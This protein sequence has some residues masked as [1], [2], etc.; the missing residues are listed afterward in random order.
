MNGQVN[1]VSISERVPNHDSHDGRFSA[2]M[3]REEERVN[4]RI[5][6][7]VPR[8]TEMRERDINNPESQQNGG[9]L[10]Y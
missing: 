9:Y 7:F 2:Q 10:N 1:N 5:N 3:N 6:D 4:P 8:D